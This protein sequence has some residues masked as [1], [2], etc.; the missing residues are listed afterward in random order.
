MNKYRLVKFWSWKHP[1][2]SI[3]WAIHRIRYGWCDA[4]IW[5]V[6]MYLSKI[7]PA[8]LTRLSETTH[9]Y[10]GTPPYTTSEAWENA[11][12]IHGSLLYEAYN[13][14]QWANPYR[15]DYEKALEKTW[16]VKDGIW[17]SDVPAEL[18]KKYLEQETTN[19]TE[20]S[21][22]VKDTFN[23][24]GENFFHLWD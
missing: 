23:W 10:P 1:I 15:E 6:D 12:K 22:V 7:I 24:I 20:A 2:Q 17:T 14:E 8:C 4:D 9:G 5:N 3:K 19:Y 16:K 21:R 18:T 11:L 13:Y